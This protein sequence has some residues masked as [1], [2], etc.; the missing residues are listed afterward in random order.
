MVKDIGPDPFVF[1][2][3]Q[4]TVANDKYRV[5]AWTGKYLQ[6][7]LMSIKPGESIGFEAHPETDQFLRVDGGTGVCIMGPSE[8][9]ITVEKEVS[10][11]SAI[12]VP[13]G[14]WHDVKNT[15]DEPLSIYAIYAPVHHA[16]GIVQDTFEQAEADEESGKD[17]PPSWTVQPKNPQP[18]QHA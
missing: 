17:E 12:C 16:A 15:G 9:N 18:D 14:I 4:E 3:E 7:T 10:D 5:V 13:A 1:D 6:V 2:I 8:D 11:G